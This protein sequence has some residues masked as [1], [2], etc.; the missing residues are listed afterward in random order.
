[1]H[2]VGDGPLADAVR[3]IRTGPSAPPGVCLALSCPAGVRWAADGVAQAFDDTGPLTAPVALD[4]DT[5]TDLGSVTKLVA[6]TAAL[7]VLTGSGGL[8]VDDRV[9]DLLPEAAGHPVAGATLADLLGHRAG[10]WEWWPLYLDS[11]RGP[12]ATDGT[13][14][15]RTVV[16]LPLRHRPGQGRHYSDLGFQLLGRVVAR[17]G[18]ADLAPVVDDLVLTPFGLSATHFT[19]PV[20]GGPVAASSN[21]DDIEAEMVRSGEP[22]PVT[23]DAEGFTRWRRR[24]LVGEVNDGNAFHA[25]GGVAGHAGLFSTASDLL[26]FGSAVLAGLDGGGPWSGDALRRF[27]Q[28]GPDPAQALGWRRWVSRPAGVPAGHGRVEGPPVEAF[29]HTGFPG[30]AVA[31]LPALGATMALVTNRLHVSGPPAATEEMF[32]RALAGVHRDLTG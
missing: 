19:R 20:T 27:L 32:L 31:V 13:A 29:G 16:S 17:V 3:A 7:T 9:G 4:P 30:V 14:A 18:G 22:Y 25:F 11:D 1:M 6:T 2:R 23:A 5:R 26:R 24:I 10:L 28:P 21:G 12:A 15:V 8:S